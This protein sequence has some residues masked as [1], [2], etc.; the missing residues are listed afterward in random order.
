MMIPFMLTALPDPVADTHMFDDRL[1][2]DRS[3]RREERSTVTR[4]SADIDSNTGRL[5]TRAE[6]QLGKRKERRQR[7]FRPK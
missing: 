1:V 3:S 2:R 6:N 4:V 7:C 5:H